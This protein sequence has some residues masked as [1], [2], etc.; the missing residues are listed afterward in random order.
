MEHAQFDFWLGDW[1][2]TDP[3][4]GLTGT[5]SVRRILDDKVIEE[6]FSFDQEDGTV[7]TGRSHTVYV[8][9]RGWC[10]TWVDSQ[11][12]YLDFTGGLVE[13]T[14]VLERVSDTDPKVVQQM[15]WYDVTPDSLTWDWLR[16]VDGGEF[17]LAWRLHYRRRPS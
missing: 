14:M 5:N 6:S 4:T 2:V 1:V 13:G 15:R 10:Q 9:G 11:G 17:E 3:T 12:T 8:T 7:F 16:S